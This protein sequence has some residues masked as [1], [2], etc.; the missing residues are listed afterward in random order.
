MELACAPTSPTKQSESSCAGLSTQELRVRDGEEMG[1]GVSARR[2]S[3]AMP[4]NVLSLWLL[5][6]LSVRPCYNPAKVTGA[7]TSGSAVILVLQSFFQED[8]TPF[9]QSKLCLQCL[10]RP[11]VTPLC[12]YGTLSMTGLKDKTETREGR[13]CSSV[14]QVAAWQV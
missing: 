6:M 5:Q 13:A 9:Y 2:F 14:A 4:K 7:V 3:R 10:Q 12:P 11:R 8:H 1:L